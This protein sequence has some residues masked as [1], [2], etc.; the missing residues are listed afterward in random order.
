MNTLGVGNADRFD[1]ERFVSAQH[2]AYD[3]ALRE[4][5]GGK[6]RTHWMWFVFP[7]IDGLGHSAMARRYAITCLDEAK[8]FLAHPVLGARL[9]EIAEA[10]VALSE[11]SATAVFGSPDDRKLQSCAT[12]FALLSAPGSVFE[13]L[14]D[15]FFAGEPDAE[16]LRLVNT[17]HDSH[18]L[19]HS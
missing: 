18:V 4:I 1:L 13:R 6:K 7:Q 10:A 14:L 12:L 19:P 2:G 16:T 9:R 15:K 17:V 5:M 8:A 11:T 3:D